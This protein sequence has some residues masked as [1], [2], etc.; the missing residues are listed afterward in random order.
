MGFIIEFSYIYV[1]AFV[2]YILIVQMNFPKIVLFIPFTLSNDEA[3]LKKPSCY[4]LAL[5][6]FA[7]A[8]TP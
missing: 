3:V 7:H 6:E 2:T 8:I 4:L 5:T 1:V